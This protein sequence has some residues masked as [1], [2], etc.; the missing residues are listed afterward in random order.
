M[1]K[2]RKIN[3]DRFYLKAVLFSL[4]LLP[5]FGVLPGLPALRV[6]D[7]FLL[8][9]LVLLLSRRTVP[10]GFK[11]GRCWVLVGF[12]FL[13]VLSMLNGLVY[14]YAGSFGDFNQFIRFA[15][16][17]S[18]YL[19]GYSVLN[20]YNKEDYRSLF[21]FVILCGT[22]LFVIAVVQYFDILG[23]NKY[24]V[25]LVAP[26]QYETL[27]GG[28][29]HP[30][31]VGM[32]GNPNEL[33]FLFVLLFFIALFSLQNFKIKMNALHGVVFFIGILL[34]MSRG[35][36]LSMVGG[37]LSYV[38]V[39][40]MY[41]GI[42]SKVKMIAYSM[43]FALILSAITLHPFVYDKL[44]WRLA[45]AFDSGSDSAFQTR[46]DNWSE[47]IEIIKKHPILGVGPLRRADFLYAADNEWLLIWRSY[48]SVG[49]V[50]V[51]T[52]FS[53]SIFK[54]KAAQTKSFE[55]ALVISSFIYMIPTA[56]FYSL[57]IF[58]FFLFLLAFLDTQKPPVSG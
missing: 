45:L 35:S 44:T 56:V 55:V 15:K 17:I 54:R 36:F 13:F 10:V 4:I 6:D 53:W 8:F 37:F 28:Y 52:I 16:Y 18:M 2:I 47:N 48:G 51:V 20:K 39:Y 9:W 40:S 11:S 58:P 27:V 25:Q 19:L 34:T 32:I 7:I 46:L 42:L 31:P 22:V 14:G 50:F 43:F 23:L 30:R 49:L 29:L 21:S 41:Q 38:F 3:F 1:H 5:S 33:G 57:V 26:T 12:L 24:Y